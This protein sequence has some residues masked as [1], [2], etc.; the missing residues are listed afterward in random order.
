LEVLFDVFFE[1]FF[2]ISLPLSTSKF[3]GLNI[4]PNMFRQE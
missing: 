1:V 4:I 2:A 3:S